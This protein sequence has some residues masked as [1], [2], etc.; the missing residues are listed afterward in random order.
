MNGTRT[1]E[2][3]VMKFTE[4]ADGSVLSPGTVVPAVEAVPHVPVLV[5]VFPGLAQEHA[6]VKLGSKSRTGHQVDEE[7]KAESR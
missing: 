5:A 4:A 1:T 7:P 3:G 2:P 6:S